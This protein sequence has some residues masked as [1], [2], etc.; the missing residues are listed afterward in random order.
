MTIN[1]NG[2]I[3]A[4]LLLLSLALSS[5]PA[6]APVATADN[7]ATTDNN[8]ASSSDTN[9]NDPNANVPD[10]Q[11]ALPIS[12][13]QFQNLQTFVQAHTDSTIKAIDDITKSNEQFTKDFNAFVDDLLKDPNAPAGASN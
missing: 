5:F 4:R 1:L 2:R 10:D 6:F 12:L 7:S 9:S 8:S 13:K 3:L 11:L